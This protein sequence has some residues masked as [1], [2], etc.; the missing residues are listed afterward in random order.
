MEHAPPFGA[1]VKQHRTLAGLT[2]EELGE[3]L[4]LSGAYLSRVERGKDNPFSDEVLQ[5]LPLALP[6]ICL[7]RLYA[8]AER[9]PADLRGRP[10]LLVQAWSWAR[11][12]KR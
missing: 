3:K 8:L 12:Q 6:T 7:D 2:Q 5:K 10:D 9:I 4:G 1:Y 11:Q